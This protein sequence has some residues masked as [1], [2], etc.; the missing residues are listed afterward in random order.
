[1]YNY[2]NKAEWMIGTINNF[3]GLFLTINN[4]FS[5]KKKLKTNLFSNSANQV[6]VLTL[7][8]SSL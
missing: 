5:G 6:C 8:T 1:M 2:P 7:K 4:R 3:Q